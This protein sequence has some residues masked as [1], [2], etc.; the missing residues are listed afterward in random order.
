MAP[1]AN[2]VKAVYLNNALWA[3]VDTTSI[4][5]VLD[6][7]GIAPSMLQFKLNRHFDTHKRDAGDEIDAAT[8]LQHLDNVK[9]VI[10]PESV[11]RAP[12]GPFNGVWPTIYDGNGNWPPAAG[13]LDDFLRWQGV[14]VDPDVSFDSDAGAP[15]YDE[16]FDVT[17]YDYRW[18]IDKSDF[19]TPPLEK[20][21]WR[22]G[23]YVQD[24]Q[25]YQ[26][27]WSTQPTLPSGYVFG[28]EFTYNEIPARCRQQNIAGKPWVIIAEH[29]I[30]TCTAQY[31][32]VAVGAREIDPGSLAA[33]IPS[34]DEFSG[35]GLRVVIAWAGLRV[36][37]LGN[38]LFLNT[39]DMLGTAIPAEQL[40]AP[41]A[42]LPDI[43]GDV[44][45]AFI[46]DP[47]TISNVSLLVALQNVLDVV[48]N[49][50]LRIDQFNVIRFDRHKA[51]GEIALPGDGETGNAVGDVYLA[52][53]ADARPDLAFTAA[54]LAR[55]NVRNMSGLRPRA[56]P[57]ANR[58]IGYLKGKAPVSSSIVNDKP[59][60]ER[61][62][63]AGFFAAF[64]ASESEST[65]KNRAKTF[66]RRSEK[67]FAVKGQIAKPSVVP[68]KYKTHYGGNRWVTH[69]SS[70]SGGRTLVN[71]ALSSTND[72][73]S[74]AIETT[75]DVMD[76][77]GELVRRDYY[78]YKV[79][80]KTSRA[81]VSVR[82]TKPGDPETNGDDK[83]DTSPSAGG[84]HYITL[85]EP[86][87]TGFAL[88]ASVVKT[89]VAG[90]SDAPAHYRSNTTTR[91]V[92]VTHSWSA[93]GLAS[94]HRQQYVSNVAEDG[95]DGI[96]FGA[97]G[98]APSSEVFSI[99]SSFNNGSTNDWQGALEQGD[100]ADFPGLGEYT[101]S[102]ID[103]PPVVKSVDELTP[104]NTADDDTNWAA[105]W[106]AAKL[107]LMYFVKN[108]ALRLRQLV[109]EGPVTLLYDAD[110]RLNHR[111]CVWGTRDDTEAGRQWCMRLKT[112]LATINEIRLTANDELQ[113]QLTTRNAMPAFSLLEYAR[114]V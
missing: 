79:I 105:R 46:P 56:V 67:L 41:C 83:G 22:S 93:R 54:Q 16:A 99:D 76:S 53:F 97:F 2:I 89:F 90:D 44:H 81:N 15:A 5:G 49:F 13:T 39:Y 31:Q 110:L 12:D 52:R 88:A 33:K 43:T 32:R 29:I 26:Y 64:Y 36:D 107:M 87:Y 61:E 19:R 102:V 92:Y 6:S 85:D 65:I 27:D 91:V 40:Y 4:T 18:C 47:I 68:F 20:N 34:Y 7:W 95:D 74:G 30:R 1:T 84:G 78:R 80:Y 106:N 58:V 21:V 62:M 23:E 48:G 57:E 9:L 38:E 73:A 96:C 75:V 11:F 108:Q 111:L 59:E 17:C 82:R 70:I 94:V 60:Q 8:P 42:A 69:Q 50:R 55:C 28:T 113:V 35:R 66:Y 86:A 37:E 51:P 104:S 71:G 10:V 101:R 103:A 112:M 14:Y 63:T 25:T 100:P 24:F 45:R 77:S 98:V 3:D 72:N 109:T 114:R